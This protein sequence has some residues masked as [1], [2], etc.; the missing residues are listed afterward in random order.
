MFNF[1]VLKVFLSKHLLES[2]KAQ[3]AILLCLF[4]CSLAAQRVTLDIKQDY[5]PSI[6]IKGD[7]L[8]SSIQ[9]GNHWVLDG[10]ELEGVNNQKLIGFKSGTYVV[11]VIDI[12]TGCTAFSD[13][14]K[15]VASSISTIHKNDLNF[16]IYPNPTNGWFNV[17]IDLEKLE[18]VTLELIAVDGKKLAEKKFQHKPGKQEVQFG[19]ANL[20]SG[21]YTVRINF[22]SEQIIRK[23]IVN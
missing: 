17:S 11:Y 18:M 21:V 1:E 16:N 14:L 7:T 10:V 12:F 23:L 13:P 15:V 9:Y 6:T 2:M 8:I 3:I 5:V 19:K 22:G 20:S 4:S